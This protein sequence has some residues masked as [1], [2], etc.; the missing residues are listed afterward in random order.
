[1]TISA[2]VP[3]LVSRGAANS[4]AIGAPDKSPLTYSGLRDA[5]A[6]TRGCLAASGLGR[7]NRIG[8]VLP[9]G[10]EMAAAFV[11][12][13]AS[14]TAVPL[15]PALKK[16]EFEF[17]FDDLGV[18]ALIVRH[19]IES[20]AR[21]VAQARNLHVFEL[22]SDGPIAG[23]FTL[24]CSR[25]ASRAPPPTVGDAQPDDIALLLHT[26]GTT[27]KSKTV[28]LL[29]RNIA[30]SA[31]N[32]AASLALTSDDVCLNIMPLFHIHGLVAALLATISAGA[33]V[34]CS[35]GLNAFRF[36]TW[37][38]GC[39]PTW[40]TAVPTMHQTLLEIAPRYRDVIARGRLRFVRSSSA[41]L[42]PQ[43]MSALETTFGVPVIEAYGMTEASHQ[44]AT[45][46]LPP[47]PRY[48]GS[49]GTGAGCEIA[50]LGDNG[51]LL[52]A[53]EQG[54]VVIRGANVTTG[55]LNNPAENAKSFV[56]GWFRTGDVGVLD[57]AGYLRLTGRL[58]EIINR[59]GE[60]VSPLEVDNAIMEH[61]AVQQV[62]TFAMPSRLFG[63]DVASAVVLRPGA[64]ADAED[65]RTFV[66]ERLAAF[67]VPRKIVFLDEIPK[68]P[69]GKLQRIGLAARLSISD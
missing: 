19:G 13:A 44:M 58:K 40:Y 59:A 51:Q 18:Q 12:V 16:E 4:A 14:A 7:N 15:N 32:I 54:E 48:A 62:A 10:P 50:I 67:K 24:S 29:Q 52:A 36:F 35:P 41:S 66:A 53:G 47:R 5:V 46:P 43:V 56:N 21:D 11:A 34:V 57:E 6:R 9:N 28:P 45:N 63:E 60:K 27:A 2:S 30:A 42:P 33:S 1:V 17:G 64:Q 65:I 23:D 61:P 38:E 49:V 31:G 39:R 26:S 25:E 3:A 55:Y 68:G 20:P 69:T 8:I 37:F 22:S